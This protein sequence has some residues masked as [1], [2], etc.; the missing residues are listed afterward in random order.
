MEEKK[1]TEEEKEKESFCNIKFF[2]SKVIIFYLIIIIN[3]RQMQ[4]INARQIIFY[5]KGGFSN[6][7]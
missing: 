5:L 6:L 3:V 1:E 2:S 4:D 7:C